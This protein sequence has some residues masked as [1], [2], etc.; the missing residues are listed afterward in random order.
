MDRKLMAAVVS[1]RAWVDLSE[2]LAAFDNV[3]LL[4]PL[5]NMEDLKKAASRSLLDIV[6]ID[7]EEFN[8]SLNGN[9]VNFEKLNL[10]AVFISR[11]NDPSLMKAAMRAG[12]RDFLAGQ[13]GKEEMGDLL[14]RA[15]EGRKYGVDKQGKKSE[16]HETGETPGKVVTFF[17]TKGG[18]GKSA[19]AVNYA[20]ALSQLEKCRVCL[21]DLDLQFGDLAL[22]MNLK[23]RASISDLIASGSKIEDEI[24]SY[25]LKRDE[26][27]FL[28]ASP[29][30]P[31]ESELV[32]G[33]HVKE[34]VGA[35]TNKFKYIIID[36]AASFHDVSLAA[37]DKSDV[38]NIVLTPIILAVKDLKGMLDVMTRSLEYPPEKIKVILNRS[39][40]QSGISGND[41]EKLCKRKMDY[42][43][44]SDGNVVVPSINTGIPAVISYPRSK[45][46]KAVKKMA[47]DAGDASPVAAGKTS[48]FKF[49]KIKK[50]ENKK[51]LN[52]NSE[53]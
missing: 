40:S 53:A 31:E 36:T 20:I 26:N 14:N 22:I 25:L 32:T 35:L 47:E 45:F 1:S 6:F 21:L 37:L 10:Y 52:E 13:V 5:Q 42:S 19:L 29:Q 39:D 49:F 34:I 46:S 41:I 16:E 43:I 38:I 28:L 9:G 17:S 24:N 12:G 11:N 15:N 4:S 50:I 48:F 8:P 7:I 44:P 33:E 3:E 30:K 2:S 51:N 23:P 18:A 27:V